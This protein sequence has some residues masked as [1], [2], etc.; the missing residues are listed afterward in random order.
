MARFDSQSSPI[1][2]IAATLTLAYMSRILA[3]CHH[4]FKRSL[5][6]AVWSCREAHRAG[7]SVRLSLR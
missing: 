2:V 5:S 4:I 6:E 7:E 3:L 1:Y